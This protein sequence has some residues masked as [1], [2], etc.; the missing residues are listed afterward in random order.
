MSLYY[1]ELWIKFGAGLFIVSL[2][3]M[4]IG[5]IIYGDEAWNWTVLILMYPGLI[6]MLGTVALMDIIKW[7]KW[8][9]MNNFSKESLLGVLL[10]GAR[11]IV[12][13]F[14]LV[15]FANFEIKLFLQIIS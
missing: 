3:V 8:A 14:A 11:G 6:L 10:V 4:V 13:I 7:L 1:Q 2:P 5:D 12:F 15:M 9:R